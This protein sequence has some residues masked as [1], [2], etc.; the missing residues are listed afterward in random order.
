M[1]LTIYE[2][3]RQTGTV[4]IDEQ[5]FEY[6]GEHPDIQRVLTKMETGELTQLK[7]APGDH[8]RE[9]GGSELIP[10]PEEAGQCQPMEEVRIGGK[11]LGRFLQH[12]IEQNNVGEGGPQISVESDT[13]L[14]PEVITLEAGQLDSD[15]DPAAE[16]PNSEG[17]DGMASTWG[18]SSE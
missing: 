18:P 16:E 17:P 4:D 2:D 3:D 14:S 8:E 6:D 5:T 12:V 13:D 7:P 10:G 15:D 9:E 1:R 11:H